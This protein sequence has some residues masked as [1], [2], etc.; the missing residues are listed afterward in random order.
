MEN[1]INTKI[2]PGDNVLAVDYRLWADGKFTKRACI[3][4]A[5]VVEVHLCE[6]VPVGDPYSILV[7]I[8]FYHRGLA[9][10]YFAEYLIREE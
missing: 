5:T 10:S 8:Y 9:R 4:P 1:Y 6:N 7:D 2:K 3:K